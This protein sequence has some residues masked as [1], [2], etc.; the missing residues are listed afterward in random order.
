ML[1]F[2]QQQKQKT[3]LLML[4]MLDLDLILLV[5]LVQI[6]LQNFKTWLILTK[7]QLQTGLGLLQKT[8]VL[9]VHLEELVLVYL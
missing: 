6:L 7:E 9:L 5:E 4:L 2:Q 1:H 3:L 8:K